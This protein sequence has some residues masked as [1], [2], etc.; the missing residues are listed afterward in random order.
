MSD[1]KQ[2]ITSNKPKTSNNAKTVISIL[3]ILIFFFAAYFIYAKDNPFNFYL[4]QALSDTDSAIE[5]QH[6][7][8]ETAENP[9]MSNENTQTD[10]LETITSFAPKEDKDEEDIDKLS[11]YEAFV[12]VDQHRDI[13]PAMPKQNFFVR[14][15]EYRLY[16]ANSQKL[17]KKFEEGNDFG[18]EIRYVK[19]VILPKNIRDIVANLDKYNQLLEKGTIEK[20][21][22]VSILG[23]I[24]S[25]F[26]K[27]RKENPEYKELKLLRT[28]IKN[29]I[30]IFDDYLYSDE[31]MKQ[32][33]EQ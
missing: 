3:F 4:D 7:N 18:A 16:L 20:Y 14:V 29:Q 13:S 25:R 33:I 21:T 12:E 32:F 9:T 10:D 19:K 6:A 26:I 30:T 1:N 24:F 27:I 17:V 28:E 8:P 31:F 22:E 5:E 15:G 23:G 11:P 2:T